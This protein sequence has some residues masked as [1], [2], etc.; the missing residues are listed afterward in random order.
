MSRQ[1]SGLMAWLIQ[2]AT[3]VYLALFL[4]YVLVFFSFAAPTDHVALREW[5][6]NPWVALGWLLFLPLL[7]AHAWVGIRDVLID[8]V[9]HLGTRITLLTLFA[10]VFVASGLWAFK[11]ILTAGLGE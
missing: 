6:T 8:Y 11:A 5:I 1:A 9:H 7:L 4:G 3:A 2:R 10:F